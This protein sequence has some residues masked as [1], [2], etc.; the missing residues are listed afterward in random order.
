MP[1]VGIE[2][3]VMRVSMQGSQPDEGNVASLGC[4]NATKGQSTKRQEDRGPSTHTAGIW[5]L[6][7]GET[8]E[9][10]IAFIDG[11]L[12]FGAFFNPNPLSHGPSVVTNGRT[13]M[14]RASCRMSCH[15]LYRY[16]VQ[17]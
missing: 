15:L 1:V 9:Q 6:E 12:E 5:T 17:L 3:L 13:K 2:W 14:L 8:V 10:R 7:S 16:D 4:H 11:A